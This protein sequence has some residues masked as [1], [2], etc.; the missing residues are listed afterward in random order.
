MCL[1]GWSRFI[2][3]KWERKKILKLVNAIRNG[4]VKMDDDE[5]KVSRG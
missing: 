2:P 1:R 5:K 3:S 4:W